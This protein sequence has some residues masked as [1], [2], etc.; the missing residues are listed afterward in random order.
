MGAIE[1]WSSTLDRRSSLGGSTRFGC[2]MNVQELLEH[3]G[4]LKDTLCGVGI[5]STS[6]CAYL[7]IAWPYFDLDVSWDV[8]GC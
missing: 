2:I 1:R 5:V 3:G 8:C 7:C 4:A 6:L